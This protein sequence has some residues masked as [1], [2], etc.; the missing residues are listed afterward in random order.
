MSYFHHVLVK[1]TLSARGKTLLSLPGENTGWRPKAGPA[2][3]SRCTASHVIYRDQTNFRTLQGGVT[4]QESC[5]TNIFHCFGMRLSA[6]K[7]SGLKSN[8]RNVNTNQSSVLPLKHLNIS[9]KACS[10]SLNG[11]SSLKLTSQHC[12]APA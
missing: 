6:F 4:K 2:N 3:I 12:P 1:S 7:F 8:L 5:P 11:C 10:G 9:R